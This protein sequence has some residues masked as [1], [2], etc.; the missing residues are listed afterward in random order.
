MALTKADLH[1]RSGEPEAARRCLLGLK[2]DK[3]SLLTALAD[4]Q[5]GRMRDAEQALTKLAEWSEEAQLHLA[6]FQIATRRHQK[7]LSLLESLR[8][9]NGDFADAARHQLMVHCETREEATLEALFDEI[10]DPWIRR[11]AETLLSTRP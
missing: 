11:E 1:L 9:S 6:L 8:A 7:G 5:S 2:G 4:A 3:A 10:E